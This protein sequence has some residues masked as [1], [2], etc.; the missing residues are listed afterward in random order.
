LDPS[1]MFNHL[2]IRT[3]LALLLGLSA[4]AVVASIAS[5][6]MTVH[7]RMLQDRVDKLR[8]V[9]QSTVGIAQAVE[10]QVAAKT[11]THDQAVERLRE[12]LRPM[13]FDDGSGYVTMSADDGTVIIQPADPSREGKPSTAKDANGRPLNALYADA[14][15]NSDGGVVR[16]EFPRP[17]QTQILG[18][19]AYVARFAPW[20]AVVLSG[21]Y[22]DDLDADFNTALVRLS[23]FGGLILMLTV[24]VAFVVNR[25][26]SR[27]LGHL[28]DAMGRLAQGD[29]STTIPGDNRTDELGVMAR[30]LVVFKDNA[31]RMAALQ[32]EQQAERQQAINDKR[33]AMISLADRFDQEVRGV[34]NK[35]ATAGG[36]MGTAARQVSGTA[37]A[38]LQHA[39][40]A[41]TDADQATANVEGVAA[42]IEEM[43][44]TGAEISRQVA[45]AATIS[46]DA[47][48]E[49]R[50]TNETVAGLAAAAQKVGD[51]VKLIQDIAAQTNLLALNAT[52][53]AARAGD[54]GKGFAVVAGEVKSLA[55]QTAKATEDIRTQIA[56]IQAESSS[57][58]AAI[59]T[60]AQTV[61]GV[62]EIATAISS[63]VDQ[64]SLAIQEVS[65]NIQQAASRTQQVGHS[66]RQMSAGLGDNGLAA[67]GVLVAADALGQQADVLRQAVDGFLV[68]VR[69]A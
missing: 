67:K 11:L 7:D 45:R 44:A 29:L 35:V 38:A 69:A 36:E 30:A 40:S 4:L 34:V 27:T 24:V 62:E 25:D 58:L 39:G 57:A 20:H 13:R 68:T 61:H 2:R 8:A 46:R 50:R 32:Q 47:A 12:V 49:G 65:G 60:I 6:A 42:A 41:M 22:T 26:I 51:V 15:R 54:A 5:G 28:G 19:I 52:I 55:N 63:T 16:Y 18:K 59:R 33:Q 9:V 14:L 21:A 1:T 66:L 56:S 23:L 31:G 53:E 3:K 17:G 48:E 37:E 43:A 64:Q 10:A